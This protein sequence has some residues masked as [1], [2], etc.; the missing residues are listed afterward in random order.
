MKNKLLDDSL[1]SYIAQISQ[2]EVLSNEEQLELLKKY[3]ETQRKYRANQRR[4]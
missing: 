4:T 2:Y 1:Q 3:R